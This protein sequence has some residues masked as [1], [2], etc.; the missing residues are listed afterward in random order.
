MH[1]SETFCNFAAELVYRNM[2]FRDIIGQEHVKGQLRQYVHDGRIAHALLFTGPQGA[3]KLPLALAYAQYIACSNRTDDDACG[4][5]STCL[6]FQRLQH[7]D[8]HFA[9]PIVKSNDSSKEIVCNDS[10]QDWREQL[11]AQPYFDLNDW[12][13]RLGSTNKQGV[14][15]EKES[16]EIIRKLSLKSFSGGYKFMIIWLPEKMNATAAN[17]IL[18]LLEE[19]PEQTLFLLVSEQPELLLST[20]VSRTQEIRVPKLSDDEVKTYLMQKGI[21]ETSAQDLAHIA[22]G[23]ITAADKLAQRT[24]QDELFFDQFSDI[25]QNIYRFVTSRDGQ[26]LL[27]LKNWAQGLSKEAGRERLKAFLQ[28]MQRQ[29]RENY[30]ANYG[31]PRINYQTERERQFSA[32]YSRLFGNVDIEEIMQQLTTAEEQIS[33]NGSAYIIFFDLVVQMALSIK[34][35][36]NNPI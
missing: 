34:K 24:E 33:Q 29:I 14:I 23:S 9:F 16:S 7:P 1:I 31:I 18:K 25:I 12:Y 20:I 4:V 36:I 8:L 30:I 6:Q 5:C 26:S 22:N 3:G 11:T 2:R 35:Q 21:D 27:L 13:A 28:Y 15:F 10:I 19:P 32:R 17:K